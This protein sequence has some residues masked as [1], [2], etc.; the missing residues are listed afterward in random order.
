M[1]GRVCTAERG[2]IGCFCAAGAVS[3]CLSATAQS[4]S[5]TGQAI[6]KQ[7]GEQCSQY[8]FNTYGCRELR[9]ALASTNHSALVLGIMG[10]VIGTGVIGMWT[11]SS[12]VGTKNRNYT[13]I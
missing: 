10:L 2:I 3:L 1:C 6:A 11:L 7:I 8:S 12:C 5:F 13:E 9:D 4:I